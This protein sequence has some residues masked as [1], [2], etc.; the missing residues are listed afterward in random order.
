MPADSVAIASINRHGSFFGDRFAILDENG[1]SIHTACLAVGM[2]RWID[3][4]PERNT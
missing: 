4:L 1:Q 2:D 3:R